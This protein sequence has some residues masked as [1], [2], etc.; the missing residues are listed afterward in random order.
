VVVLNGS[1]SSGSGTPINLEI[2]N[3][4]VGTIQPSPSTLTTGATTP[5]TITVTGNTFVPTS[6]VQVNGSARATTY[7]NATT[8]TF[9]AT[10]ADQ[11]TAGHLLSQ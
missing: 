5:A 7:V 1:S 6:V 4:A 3:P 2:D 8:L 10:V 11:A 9:I